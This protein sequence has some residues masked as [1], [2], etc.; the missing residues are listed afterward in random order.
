MANDM[1]PYCLQGCGKQSSGF[2]LD[3]H[4]AKPIHLNLYSPSRILSEGFQKHA[5][6]KRQAS[7]PPTKI[8]S[9]ADTSISSDSEDYPPPP[10]EVLKKS[11]KS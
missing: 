10:G 1:D 9:T 3:G 11:K 2:D 7:M 8:L 5:D 6:I 4:Q